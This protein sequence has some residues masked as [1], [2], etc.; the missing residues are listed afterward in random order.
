[1]SFNTRRQ[2][3]R[4]LENQLYNVSLQRKLTTLRAE[5]P[6][7]QKFTSWPEVLEILHDRSLSD[8]TKD[9]LLRPLFWTRTKDNDAEWNV[10]LTLVF[11][12]TLE[13]VFH[14]KRKWDTD[15]EEFWHHLYWTFLEAVSRIDVTKRPHRLGAKVYND[16]LHDLYRRYKRQWRQRDRETT[17]TPKKYDAL[18]TTTAGD[19]GEEI[20]IQAESGLVLRN[21]SR[22]QRRGVLSQAE[23]DLLVATDLNGQTVADFAR[24]NSLEYQMVKKRRQRARAKIYR[25]EKNSRKVQ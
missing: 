9:D 8:K 3:R 11:W 2:I 13:A 16:T 23:F 12:P 21:L 17:L 18:L 14:K 25:A 19:T 20:V 7:Y 1:M 22:L 6:A 15:A 4:Q 24:E 10:I 5:F